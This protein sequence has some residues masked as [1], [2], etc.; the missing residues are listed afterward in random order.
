M[1]ETMLISEVK[2]LFAVVHGTINALN[3][4]GCINNEGQRSLELAC[5]F[6]CQQ[7]DEEYQRQQPQAHP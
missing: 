6:F 2:S 4:G 3:A 7:V 1:K 5:K